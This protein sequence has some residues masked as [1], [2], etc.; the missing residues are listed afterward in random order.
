MV[1][2]NPE[3]HR[4]WYEKN[5]EKKR[6]YSHE[7]YKKHRETRLEY[8]KQYRISNPEFWKKSHRKRMYGLNQEMFDTLVKEHNNQCAICKV[9]F[10]RGVKNKML[11][12]DH[13]HKTNKIRG[14]LCNKCNISLGHLEKD[15]FLEAALKYL[16]YGRD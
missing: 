16:K 7:Y 2:Y 9:T 1:N 11:S 8:A 12:I 14:L 15:G 3:T 4:K 10:E 6:Q 5:A 13:C